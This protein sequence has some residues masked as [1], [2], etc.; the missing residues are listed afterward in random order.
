MMGY[1]SVS[2]T[3]ASFWQHHVKRTIVAI[4]ALALT[5]SVAWAT[6]DKPLQVVA[7]FS[8][9]GDMVQQVGGEAVQVSAIV[10]AEGDAHSFEPR[11]S[12]TK[13]LASA[14]LVVMNGLEFEAWM[15]RLA[16]SAGYTGPQVIVSQGITPIAYQDQAH[17]SDHHGDHHDDHDHD[18]DHHGHQ[19]GEFDPH[20]WQ[21]LSNAVVYVN[22]IRDAL[23]QARPAAAEQFHANAEAYLAQLRD[24]DQQLQAAF[25]AL[26]AERRKVITSHDAFAY[27]GA[28]YNIEFIPLLGVSNLAEPSAQ[29]IAGLIDRARTEGISAIFVENVV[30]P[31]L[32][33]QVARETGAALGGV[34]YSDALAKSPHD[35]DTYLGLIKW[36][37]TKLLQALAP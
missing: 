25:A 32:V 17:G 26:P 20:A 19:H 30:S 14:E 37:T 24:L 3:V 6:S 1:R 10:G 9:L 5:S 2:V 11:P 29:E 13:A 35:A 27:L 7:S 21:S 33:E 36:N 8:I 34:L 4:S 16:Q 18:H 22:N 12:D 23:I 28:E 31:R 15:P